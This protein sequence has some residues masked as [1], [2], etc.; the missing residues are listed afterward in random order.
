MLKTSDNWKGLSRLR[1]VRYVGQVF[2][3]TVIHEE[4][5]A[6]IVH[7]AIPDIVPEHTEYLTKGKHL[8]F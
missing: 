3:R 7:H 5:A 2:V 4:T 8:Y 1:K 6:E